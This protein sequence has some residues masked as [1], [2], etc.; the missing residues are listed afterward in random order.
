MIGFKQI[1]LVLDI[2]L[3]K[4]G[5]NHRAPGFRNQRIKRSKEQQNFAA[6]LCRA[7]QRI[8]VC[9]LPQLS[10]VQPGWIKTNS[11]LYVRLQRGA[12]GQMSANAKTACANLFGG[13]HRM[14]LQIIQYRTAIFVK[15]CQRHRLLMLHAART[16]LV[17]LRQD[18]ASGFQAMKD[19]M[20][21]DDKSISGEPRT[22]TQH[23]IAQLKDVRKQQD[24][25]IL[26]RCCGVGDEHTHGLAGAG[27]F[28]VTSLDLH[29]IVYRS[30]GGSPAVTGRAARC[31]VY[32]C[33][34]FNCGRTRLR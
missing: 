4:R 24:A 3:S 9:P 18:G 34:R 14:L 1:S 29:R 27:N 13:N 26:P 10:V 19:F 33:T 32:D 17:R 22:C 15:V 12:K 5:F 30:A 6:N 20:R 8:R 21:S 7:V 16:A 25:G 2:C 23:G 31:T 11:G 28:D